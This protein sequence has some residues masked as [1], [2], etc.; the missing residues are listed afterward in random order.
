MSE[1]FVWPSLEERA[2]PAV[3]A[4]EVEREARERGHREGYERGLDEGR[5]E[6]AAELSALRGRLEESLRALDELRRE[7]RDRDAAGL[8]DAAHALCRRVVGCE[9]RT[10]PET[11]E[12]VLNEGLARLE[13][14]TESAEVHLNP[15]DH[16]WLQAAGLDAVPMHPDPEVPPCG[17]SIRV[18]A[19]AAEFDPMA[20]MDEVFA[21]VRGDLGA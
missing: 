9:L 5:R 20:V 13:T 19:C 17:I 7:T 21:E 3:C 11:F 12:H 15:Q 8:A 6:L 10:S 14:G 16:A 2:A 18:A 4:E 1:A